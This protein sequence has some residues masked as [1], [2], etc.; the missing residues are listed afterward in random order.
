MNSAGEIFRSASGVVAALIAIL[1]AIVVLGL[2]VERSIQ[3]EPSA[4]P[5]SGPWRD[6]P[7]C[8]ARP[9]GRRAGS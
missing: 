7:P 8:C 3:K 1:I 6:A 5:V 4:F 9:A 2:H